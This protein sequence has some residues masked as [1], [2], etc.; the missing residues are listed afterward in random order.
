MKH[1]IVWLI[2][3]A[4]SWASWQVVHVRR[5]VL[6]HEKVRRSKLNK[7]ALSVVDTLSDR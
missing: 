7:T 3:G 2:V 6:V 1:L 4:A 5:L